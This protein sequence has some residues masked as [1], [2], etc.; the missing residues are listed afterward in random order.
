MEI[1]DN[2]PKSRKFSNGDPYTHSNFVEHFI[3]DLLGVVHKS[4]YDIEYQKQFKN[5]IAVFI[6]RLSREKL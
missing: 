5:E 6:Y 2:M 1:S 3:E 4:G